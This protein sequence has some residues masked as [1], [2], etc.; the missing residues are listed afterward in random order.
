MHSQAGSASGVWWASA[1]TSPRAAAVLPALVQ[2]I[3]DGLALL[4]DDGCFLALSPSA[5]EVLGLPQAELLGCPAPFG[6]EPETDESIGL[7]TTGWT[8][9]GGRRR[10]LEYRVAPAPGAGYAVWF[11]DV[12]NARRQQERLRAIAR[13]AASVAGAGTLRAT[14]D[15]VAREV[16][17]TANIAAVQILA[18]DDPRAELRVLG[19]AGFGDAADFTD[20]LAA[21]R[22]RGADVRFLDALRHGAPVVVPHRKPVIMGDPTWAPLHAIMGEPD[23]DGFVSMPM[24]MRG[25]AIG[26]INAYY[27]PGEDPGPG[28]LAF[29]EA[30]ADHAAVAIHTA[31]L[32]DRTRS[33]AQLDERKRLARDLHDSVVQQLFSMRMQASALRAHVDR[34]ERDPARLCRDAEELGELAQGALA[35]LRRLIF[36]LRPLDLT[37]RGLVETVRA[38]AAGLQART[39]LAV[40]VRTPPGPLPDLGVDVEE[41][42]YRVVSEALHNVVKH[43]RATAVDICFACTPEE[44]VVEVIDDGCGPTTVPGTG[45]STRL[46]LVS[47]HERTE[48]WGGR[49][50]AGPYPAGGWRVR[51]TLPAT[52][53]TRGGDDG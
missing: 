53:P 2:V 11:K 44:L 21:C 22:D 23:W 20:R 14:L 6:I 27:V 35:D 34:P 33:Q 36:E 15:A 30:M 40:E 42:L 12:T 5:A 17:R 18:I 31:R 39:G 46:G 24:I 29:L 49:L 47:M 8:V 41:D 9:R 3:A 51:V 48:R 50:K 37:E 52:A 13:A 4:D 16:A 45:E 38:H 28:S 25:R 1:I 32:L 43:A 26:V 10:E 7:R 19:M